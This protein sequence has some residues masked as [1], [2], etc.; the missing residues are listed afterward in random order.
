MKNQENAFTLPELL[1]VIV[2]LSVLTSTALPSFAQFIEHNQ[3]QA[4]FYQLR[5]AIHE[6]R[7]RAV[8]ERRRIELCASSDGKTCQGQWSEGW[9]I[10]GTASRELLSVN[11]QK[12]GSN[13]VRWSGFSTTIKFLPNGTSPLSNGRFYQCRKGKPAWQIIISR[14]G[15]ARVATAADNGAES[16]RCQ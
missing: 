1:I 14:Q 2:L 10:R 4:V 9:I 6:A 11:S 7:T 15:R 3:Q 13:P 8:Q 12:P 5:S 16:A